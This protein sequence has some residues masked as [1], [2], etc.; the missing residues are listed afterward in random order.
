MV[1][2]KDN[3]LRVIG[4]IADPSFQVRIWKE[5]SSMHDIFCFEEAVNVLSDYHF[6]DDLESE[7]YSLNESEYILIKK[8]AKSLLDYPD[9]IHAKKMLSDSVWL[10]IVEQAKSAFEVLSSKDFI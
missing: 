5:Q 2:K 6:F 4:I 10:E 3:V 7:A 8:F 9:G 1:D